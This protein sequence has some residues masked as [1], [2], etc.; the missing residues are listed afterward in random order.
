MVA[1]SSQFKGALADWDEMIGSK[2]SCTL[3]VIE[4]SSNF[5][6][7]LSESLTKFLDYHRYFDC[8]LNQAWERLQQEQLPLSLILCDIDFFKE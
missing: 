5:S 8:Y 1:G 7:Y 6:E 3:Y 2:V 4:T